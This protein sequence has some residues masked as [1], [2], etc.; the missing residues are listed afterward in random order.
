MCYFCREG[1]RGFAGFEGGGSGYHSGYPLVFK[2]NSFQPSYLKSR[3]FKEENDGYYCSSSGNLCSAAV[4]RKV[5]SSQAAAG[6]K[7]VMASSPSPLVQGSLA[8]LVA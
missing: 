2:N 5:T 8:W 4:G 6:M 7:R 3:Y 1:W